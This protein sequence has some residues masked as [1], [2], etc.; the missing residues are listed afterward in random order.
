MN[1]NLN[2]FQSKPHMIARATQVMSSWVVGRHFDGR[3]TGVSMG[4]CDRVADRKRDKSHKIWILIVGSTWASEPAV[5]S[6]S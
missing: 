6:E 1:N 2:S 5:L 4:R 3:G